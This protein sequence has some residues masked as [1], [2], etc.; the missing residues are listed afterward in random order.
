ML[1]LVITFTALKNNVKIMLSSEGI[2]E[3][4]VGGI[5]LVDYG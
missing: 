4:A 1:F 5:Q 2:P 3:E